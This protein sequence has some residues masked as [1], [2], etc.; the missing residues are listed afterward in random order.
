MDVYV[1]FRDFGFIYKEDIES[2]VKFVVR[3]G[4]I[5]VICMVNINFIVDNE[6]IFNYVKE[7][8]KNVCINVL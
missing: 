8:L 4:F 7:K 5:I 1:Y 6:D 2:G 3:G